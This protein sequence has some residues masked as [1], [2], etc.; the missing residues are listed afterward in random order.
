VIPALGDPPLGDLR[1]ID[2]LRLRNWLRSEGRANR[3]ANLHAAV[4]VT[5]LRWADEA[6]L[7]EVSPVRRLDPLPE[8][9][10]CQVY[11]RRAL[12]PDEA[13]RFLAA[14]EAD[15]DRLG[16]RA[17]ERGRVR[18][19]V[20]PV[21]EVLLGTGCRYGEARLA[22]WGDVDLDAGVMA[23]RAENTKARRARALPLRSALV[24]GLRELRHVHAK[25]LDR[26]PAAHDRVLLTPRG[27]PWPWHT[28][29]LTRIFTRLLQA[30]QIS[31]V[32][33]VGERVDVHALRHSFATRLAQS[34]APLMHAQQLL[35]H[36]S[37][38]L[39]ARVYSHLVTADLRAVVEA[40]EQA[41]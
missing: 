26:E 19:P 21:W 11:R 34:G 24:E 25:A 22:T 18:V 9:R 16:A 12:T 36:A 8:S 6:G 38:V 32:D 14:S 30:A 13:R 2:L 28:A 1:P 41:S 29:S 17:A 5:M 33:A 39:T 20:T 7:I 40:A 31:K 3:T 15:D 4:V 23:L 37:P 10:D 35:G 27:L